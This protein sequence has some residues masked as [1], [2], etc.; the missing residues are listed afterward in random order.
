MSMKD[1]VWED[2]PSNPLI[3]PPGREW[4][5]ADPSFLPPE[6]GPDSKWHLFAHSLRGIHHYISDD[7][8]KWEKS[9]ERLF[10]GLRPFLFV[11]DGRYILL[12][13]QY[14]S[15]MR[16]VVSARTS[17]DLN[18]WSEPKTLVSPRHRWEGNL[19]RTN[20]NPCLVKAE[21]EYRLYFSAGSV[22]LPDCGFPEPRYIGMATADNPL[23][24]YRK[25]PTPIIYR[26]LKDKWRNMGAGAVKI[27]PD[28]DG[29]GW[30]GFNNGIYRD[31]VGKSRSAILLIAS[32]DGVNWRDIL[33]EPILSPEPGWKSAFVYALDVRRCGDHWRLYYNAR[34]GWFRGAER[35]GLATASVSG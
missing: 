17:D 19:M 7:G 11:H 2:H 10:P 33:P 8:V 28:P 3:E 5:I 22:L 26:D 1:L 25:L 27:I 24:P 9:G 14:L 32:K 12:Y 29:S 15:P 16:S 34:N 23:G 30:I 31:D 13:E 21:N 35:I 6:E 20:G 18:Q 4:I